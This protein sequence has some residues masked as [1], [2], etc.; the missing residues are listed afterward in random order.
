MVR[1]P[2]P[3]IGDYKLPNMDPGNAYAIIDAAS[4]NVLSAKSLTEVCGL[5]PDGSGFL[6]STG[7]G[8]IVAPGSN[9]VIEPDYVW[10]NHLL[11]IDTKLL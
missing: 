7:K 2:K 4:G 3:W 10:D 11:R 5:A 9:P 6:V 1:D 8:E